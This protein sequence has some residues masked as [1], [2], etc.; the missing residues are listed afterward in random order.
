MEN[1]ENLRAELTMIYLSRFREVCNDLID[2]GYI[3]MF[4]KQEA[5]NI[6]TKEYLKENPDVEPEMTCQVFFTIGSFSHNIRFKTKRNEETFRLVDKM[7][8]PNNSKI[9]I[10]D[11]DKSKYL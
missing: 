2:N 5:L 10:S 4:A 9:I 1:N 3:G 7:F 6:I 11:P 8:K